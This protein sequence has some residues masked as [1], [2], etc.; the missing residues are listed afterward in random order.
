V[1]QTLVMVLIAGLLGCPALAH[2]EGPQ[3]PEEQHFCEHEVA[4]FS[5]NTPVG[6]PYKEGKC[7]PK[8][9]K[10]GDFFCGPR[11]CQG[12]FFSTP[13]VCCVNTPENAT[14]EYSCAASELNC[15]GNTELLTIRPTSEQSQS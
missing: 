7:V 5:E 11:H 1:K 13:T 8:E 9:Q 15:P 6:T 2:A 3:C 4:Q 14:P 10:C 12:G